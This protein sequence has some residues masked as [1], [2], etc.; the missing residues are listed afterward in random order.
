MSTR[1]LSR[2]QRWRI[3]KVQQERLAR[4]ER[5]AARL[6]EGLEDATLGPEQ[7]GTLIAHYGAY[8]RVED[9][10]G[11][12]HRCLIRQNLGPLVTGDRVVWQAARNGDGVVVAVA[13]RASLLARPDPDGRMKPVAANID[14]I[15]IVV[16]PRPGIQLALID[17]YLL[18]AETTG[19]TPVILV[20]K[21]DLLDAPARAELEQCLEEFHRLGYATLYAST[22]EH[23]GLDA[24]H[25]RLRGHTSIFVGQSGVGKSSLINALLPAAEARTGELSE[26]TGLGR[27]TTTTSQLYRL[28]DDDDDG[29]SGGA[30]IDSPGI[31]EFGLWAISPE[32]AFDGFPEFRPLRGLCRFRNC[33]HR[34]EPGCALQDAAAQG[35]ISPRRLESYHRIVDSLGNE[36]A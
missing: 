35:Q 17:R 28:P 18:A 33:R 6:G 31:R 12:Q 22:R 8:A 11:S 23:H 10:A 25:A 14:Q 34:Q 2:R 26:T 21:I 19:I 9:E 27:H 36:N 32:Q 15:F 13:P 4:A 1:K 16:A 20:N 3:E 24:L 29:D 30:I 5:K 7:A